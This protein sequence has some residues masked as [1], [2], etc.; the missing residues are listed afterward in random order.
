MVIIILWEESTV[1]TEYSLKRAWK[2]FD[3]ILPIIVSSS[4]MLPSVE[5]I[6]DEFIL[7]EEVI[8]QS[9]NNSQTC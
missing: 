3:I 4:L 9:L 1:Q 7:P 5:V 6:H 2:S 8:Q